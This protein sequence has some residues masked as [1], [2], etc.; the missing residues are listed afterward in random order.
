MRDIVVSLLIL[1][2]LPICYRRPFVG[3][4]VFSWLAY[5]RVQDLTWGFAR[6]I[7]W[8]FFVAIVTFAGFIGHRRDRWF[9]PDLRCWMMVALIV[10]LGVGIVF[11]ERPDAYQITRYTEFIKIV[12]IALFTTAVVRTRE[13][14]RV[15]VWVIALSL[16]FYGVKSGIWGIMTLGRTP[17]LRGPGGML[18]DN[19]DLSLALSMAVPML[20]HIG[21]S[22]RREVLRRAFWF[23]VPLTVITIG[24][25]HSR[26][27]FL[28]VSAAFMVL[29]WRS[30]NRV[31]GF[32]TGAL[33]V[34]AAAVLA[35][36]SYKDRLSSIKDYETEGSAR[37][38]IRSWGIAIRM[39]SANP[40]LGVGFSKYT[41]HY[42][43]YTPNPT[44]GELA[45]TAIIV[46][47][48]SYLQIWAECGTPAFL[49]YLGLV[50]MSVIS[51]WR[52]RKEARSRY[53]S[54][55]I[56]NYATMFEASLAAFIVGSTF[57]NRAHFDLFYHWVAIILVFG[58]IARREM[59]DL[60]AYPLR[61]QGR[62]AITQTVPHGFGARGRVSGFRDT[63]LL[64]ERA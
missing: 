53:Y 59:A 27:G 30:R 54:S 47:H 28:S 48:N 39:A 2:L 22:E 63:P 18:A 24:L 31:A 37:G 6:T 56:L 58:E 35:P 42:L 25:T 21:W 64:P 50:A 11:S 29:I 26:G 61:A 45:G 3:L 57:L 23:A 20:F 51:V 17:I 52:I 32:A 43:D 8:S 44:P 14:L 16:G 15:L 40:I 46:A 13:H 55:W 33:I 36:A 7:R 49:L 34:I 41:Q 5:M 4:L 1:G 10:L 60:S 38:R 9:S 62:G 19:N 12:A